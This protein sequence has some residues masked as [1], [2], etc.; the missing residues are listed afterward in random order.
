MQTLVAGVDIGNST[1]EVAVAELDFQGMARFLGSGIAPTI[2]IKGTPQNVGGVTRALNDAL[3]AVGRRMGDLRMI[4]LN[5]AT[6]VIAGVAMETIT[7]TVIT[8]S[9]MIGHNPSTPGGSGLGFG[10]TLRLDELDRAS[11]GEK[12][13]ALI[14]G[15]CDFE[16]AARQLNR[17]FERGVDVQGAIALKDDA[18]LICNRLRRAIPV[19]DE[20]TLI[21]NVPIGMMG[22]VEVA[23]PG[24]QIRVLSNPYGI[25]T[26]FN[27]S[28]EETKNIVPVARAL[29]GNRSAVVIK[30]PSGDV[31]E[32]RI[33]AGKLAFI[34]RTGR[35]QVDVQDGGQA[36][37]SALEKAGPPQDVEGEPGTNIGG[38]IRRIKGIMAELTSQS[39]EAVR[40]QD[41][42]AL[43]T[44]VPQRVRGGLADEFF[45]ENAVAIGAMV[46]TSRL[47]MQ[48][49]ARRLEA[50]TG[51]P[52]EIS[53]QEAEMAILGALTT[54]GTERPLAIVDMGGGST[55]AALMPADGAVRS[56]HLAGAGDLV[57]MLIDSRL[58]LG[59]RNL[60]EEIKIHPLARVESL[61]HIRLEDGTVRFF[62]QA[63]PPHLFARVIL[64]K[65]EG[66]A[67]VKTGHSLDHIVRVRRE[68]KSKVFVTN[69]LRA[70]KRVAPAGDIRSIDFVVMVGGSALDFEIP[71]MISDALAEYGI[72]AGG[73]NIRGT[74]GPRNAVAT[75]LVLASSAGP[76]SNT[77]RDC[78]H[79]TGNWRTAA[80]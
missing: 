56:A 34:T 72:V 52:V 18:V 74:E 31:K 35:V 73:G 50:E 5:E 7:E 19:V 28:P 71:S 66:M 61:F 3:M 54:P 67:P 46:K 23:E 26:L 14:P 4:L 77:D 64:L 51:V 1:T 53:G 22:A 32:R 55:D 20:V 16:E 57:T 44:F 25:A 15:P 42:L 8:E 40:I 11:P 78:K 80:T 65:P 10:K 41:V 2:G 29:I 76:A 13:I 75:G 63:L 36:I 60:A 39:A 37:M 48:E 68:A 45:S 70:L 30:T 12:V 38:M 27:L 79:D 24:Q 49:I 47:P 9:T 21:E 17:A 59:D 58:G 33:P 6:P 62:D 43:D 69:A